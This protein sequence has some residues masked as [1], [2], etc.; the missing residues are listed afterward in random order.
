MLLHMFVSSCT[1]NLIRENFGREYSMFMY[2]SNFVLESIHVGYLS[3]VRGRKFPLFDL[4]SFMAIF[5]QLIKDQ[6]PTG[7]AF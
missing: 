1:C 6:K 5:C 3:M 4:T 2:D 7:I